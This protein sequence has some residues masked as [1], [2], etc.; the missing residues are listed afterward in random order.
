[1]AEASRIKNKM[2][3]RFEAQATI[4]QSAVVDKKR[5]GQ[6]YPAVQNCF[7]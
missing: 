2:L 5:H 6:F 7:A 3:L 4:S 1:M